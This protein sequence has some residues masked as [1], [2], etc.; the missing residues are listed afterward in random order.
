MA[1]RF[2]KTLLALKTL[3]V[4]V[5]LTIGLAAADPVRSNEAD[6]VARNLAPNSFRPADGM[7]SHSDREGGTIIRIDGVITAV[8][9]ER[10]VDI[11]RTLPV[12]RPVIVEL[13]SPGGFTK[14]GY[15]MIDLMQAERAAGRPIATVVGNRA[16]CESMCFGVFMAGHPRYAAAGAEFM[17][18]AP[19]MA[20]NGRVTLKTTQAMIERMVRLGVSTAW[21]DQ[22]R[23]AG[24][25]SGRMDFRQNAVQLVGNGSNTV[26]NLLP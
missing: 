18:H 15:A 24:G 12:L 21:I 17:V 8:V 4:L 10:F 25:F 1:L 13:N 16:S 2:L 14:A 26:T 5:A 7:I 6:A 23:A 20:T 11:F 19:H 22:V 9:A 3:S